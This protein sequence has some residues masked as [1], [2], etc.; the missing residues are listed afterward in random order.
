MTVADTRDRIAEIRKRLLPALA[1]SE[2]KSAARGVVIAKRLSSGSLSLAELRRRGHPFRRGPFSPGPAAPVEIINVQ[3]G[4]FRAVWAQ[5][6][7]DWQDG[8]LTTTVFN[9]DPAAQ[10]MPGTKFMVARPVVEALETELAPEREANL[11]RALE[12]VL[13]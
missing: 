5:R 10:W 7:G 2:R 3:G 4:T 9:D 8:T 1:A 6:Q 11:A 13:A 12:E